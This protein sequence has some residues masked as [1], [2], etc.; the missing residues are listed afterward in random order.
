MTAEKC[1][2]CGAALT[3]NTNKCTYCGSTINSNNTFSW[4][5]IK[6]RL[7]KPSAKDPRYSDIVLKCYYSTKYDFYGTFIM[8]AYYDFKKKI[9]DNP[10]F[11]DRIKDDI[12]ASHWMPLPASDSPEWISIDKAIPITKSNIESYSTEALTSVKSDDYAVS[13][14]SACVIFEKRIWKA[15]ILDALSKKSDE[16]RGVVEVIKWMSLPTPPSG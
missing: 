3:A 9:W 12:D 8:S 10:F 7:P 16:D 4:I 6:D 11:S 13:L 2:N 14:I 15:P 1:P 5:S